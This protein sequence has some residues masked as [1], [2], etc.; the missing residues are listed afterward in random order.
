[1]LIASGRSVDAYLR[2]VVEIA[3][4]D[5]AAVLAAVTTRAATVRGL[6]VDFTLDGKVVAPSP[7]VLAVEADENLLVEA[8]PWL[9]GFVREALLSATDRRRG[10]V[11]H[12]D[13]AL[14]AEIAG[15]AIE[16]L[17]RPHVEIVVVDPAVG[18]GVFLLAAAERLEAPP[19]EVVSRLHGGD[20]DPLAVAATRAA[21]TIW[22]GGIEPPSA[23]LQVADY[24]DPTVSFP[25]ADLVIGNP[26]FLSQLKGTTARA[27]SERRHLANRWPGVG[28]YV[29]TAAA[30]MLAAVDGL[31]SGGVWALIQPDSVLG[32]SD[33]GSVR[34]RLAATAPVERILVD[35]ARRFDAAIDT[36]ALIGREG[37]SGD[38]SIFGGVP[39][40][41]LGV[42][43]L[44]SPQSWAPLL[45]PARG[46]PTVP[47]IAVA[48][49]LGDLAVTTAGFRDQF[50]GLRHAVTEDEHADVKLITSGLIDPLVNRWGATSCRYD[51]RAWLHPAVALELVA[52]D[53]HDW[54]MARLRPKVLVA[55]QTPTIEAIVDP[56]GELVPCTPVVTVE[57]HDPDD[58]WRIAALLTCPVTSA[59]LAQAASGTALSADALRVSAS[60]LAE[61]PIPADHSAWMTAAVAARAG[62]VVATGAAMQQAFGIDDPGL[63]TWWHSRLPNRAGE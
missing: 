36:V 57:P 63:V 44:P 10:G 11:H 14:A 24:L 12:T 32:A 26:P 51:K 2:R 13:P 61:L 39:A 33:A 6:V 46:V 35:D 4:A 49:T 28:R 1:V 53:I 37:S 58:V 42:V 17:D 45:A 38:V 62:D 3:T 55:S 5:H 25:G 47:E 29:D 43:S 7:E 41:E 40:S 9:I 22:S 23:N 52:D 21:L 8:G 56:V 30:F 16:L 34:A 60:R 54:V 59:L 15:L 19:S 27:I 48:G 18:G 20:V 50:Y 31:V